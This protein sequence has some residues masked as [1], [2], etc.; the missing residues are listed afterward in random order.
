MASYD[1][2]GPINEATQFRRRTV[3]TLNGTPCYSPWTTPVTVAVNLISPGVIAADQGL[4]IGNS[5]P[6]PF[7]STTSAT[8]S[9]TI[10]Y[11]WQSNTVGCMAA[12]TD[13]PMATSSTYDAPAISQTTYYR[14]VATST[15]DGVPCSAA[16]NCLTVT[17]SDNVPPV[18][19]CPSAQS[20]QCTIGELPPYASYEDFT[21]AG[22]SASD[23][24]VLNTASFT[25]V[26][27]TSDM[28]SC[29]ETITR[30]Y[31]I[32][33]Q[34]GNSSTCAQVITVD[35]TTPPSLS[36]CIESL[37]GSAECDGLGNNI[38]AAAAWN[39]ANVA[40]L[41]GCATDNCSSVTITSNYSTNASNVPGC[42]GT[43]TLTVTYTATDG[44]GNATTT[45]GVFTI[46][47]TTPPVIGTQAMGQTVQCDG[48][49]N[50]AAL[51]SW[52]DSHGGA[53]AS[54]ACGTVIWSNN[55]TAL[56]DLCGATGTAT[57]E[58]YASDGCGNTSTTTATFTIEDTT[59]PIVTCPPSITISGCGTNDIPAPHPAYNETGAFLTLTELEAAGG[60]AT[61]NCDLVE[62]EIFYQDFPS[63]TCPLV[64]TRVWTA[65]DAC[66]LLDT[67]QQIIRIYDTTFPVFVDPN[68][69]TLTTSA[70]AECPA[71]GGVTGI[72]V[73]PV[74]SGA[75]FLVHG[76]SQSAPI[77]VSPA[78]ANPGEYSDNCQASLSLVSITPGGNACS[79]TYTLLWYV[80]DECGNIVPQNQV[81]TVVD[82]T[83][84]VWTTAPGAL[85]MTLECSDAAG[86][87]AAQALFPTAS[88]N[89]DN[90]VTNIV[91]VSGPFVPGMTCPQEGTYTNTWTVTDD[92]G[93]TSLVYTQVITI[94]D[95]TAPVITICPANI[96]IE[97][98]ASTDPA[99]NTA[100]GTATAT[101]N[102]DGMPDVQYSDMTVQSMSCP[103][104]YTI[105]RT[106][107]A[108][109][110]CGN[111][112]NCVQVITIDDS[113]APVITFCP[114]DVTIECSES[115]D[116]TVNMTLGIA[117]ATDNC[118]GMPVV[119]YED[120]S[121][122]G[123]C[124]QE[125][126]I[127]RTWTATDACGNSTNCV[128]VITVDDSTPPMITA[129]ADTVINCL[130]ASGYLPLYARGEGERILVNSPMEVEGLYNT[131][132]ANFGPL[133]GDTITADIILM[134]DGVV[135]VTDGCEPTSQDMTGKIALIDR[136]VCLFTYK[137][138]NAQNAGAIA[139]IIANNDMVNPD[140]PIGMGGTDPS[141]MI[142]TVSISYNDGV[143]LKAALAAGP[144]NASMFGIPVFEVSD[145]C[146]GEPLVT[147]TDE[148]IEGNCVGNYTILRTY[149]A[150]DDCGNIGSDVQVITVIDT[151][152]PVITCPVDVTIECT[153]S[154]DPAVNSTLGVATA[155]DGC[156]D[157]PVIAYSDATLEGDCP[158]EYT[159]TRTWSATDDCGNTTTCVQVITVDDST[160]PVITCPP[161]LTIQ[162]DAELDLSIENPVIAT[163]LGSATATDN[164]DGMPEITD[165]YD[166]MAFS[167][168]CGPTGSQTVTFTATDACGNSTA[169]TAIIQVVD[170]VPPVC[171]TADITIDTVIDPAT[172]I[173]MIDPSWI[174]NG[175]FDDCGDVTISV[176][177]ESIACEDEGPNVITLT[178]TDECGNTSQCTATLTLD[179]ID[180]CISVVSWVYL[181]GS[182]TAPNGEPVWTVP[183][184]TTLNDLLVL[185]G[186]FY[187]DPFFGPQYSPPG[188]PYDVA[189]WNYMGTEG[190]AYDSNMDPMNG[191][192]N[193]PP[194]VVDWVL[195]SLRDTVIGPPVCMAAALLHNDGTIEFV[196]PFDCCDQDVYDSYY[197]VVEHRNHLIV[198]SDI[199]IPVNLVNSTITY[200]FRIQDSYLDNPFMFEFIKGQ[201]E[202]L[203]GIW[204]MYAANGEQV[205][206]GAA[207]I[208]I[209]QDDRTRWSDDNGD[210]GLYRIGDYNMNA[211]VNFNDRVTWERNNGNSSSVPRD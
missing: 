84:P 187:D 78:A 16:S 124:P 44:C 210:Y 110:A 56:S 61:D 1:P 115:T 26:S 144:V 70:G 135:P 146:T 186:Q 167:D 122:P 60:T 134:D 199:P 10:T 154:I 118:D 137:V 203:P 120:A 67:C 173:I 82:N 58:F 132:E 69:V 77:M 103:Q 17:L 185:P 31:R 90:D 35:D 40:Y 45:T 127:T 79:K 193:Y 65:V 136:N 105:T 98:T 182:A 142:P 149:Y 170:N 68:D 155:T 6:V 53:T 143:A 125:Y 114:T 99:I 27:E 181:E 129:P 7:T 153:E 73:G 30:V 161:T 41:E 139:V 19:N 133:L 152:G 189:P 121:V 97:C 96:T 100:L 162:C 51:N 43:F 22:G 88:D 33:D 93:N 171:M 23:N 111:S 204:A 148:I 126:T 37:N 12:F 200:D 14:R 52:L 50:T 141:I 59:P 108:T 196:Q 150:E 47:D 168:E 166:P 138:L 106:W 94:V 28:M 192:A 87:S 180:P 46:V 81:F 197:V 156:S 157:M 38:L 15:L 205:I 198:M 151:I 29:P 202:I 117:T 119:V 83:A 207:D 188:Q 9:G 54:D 63:G 39:N 48:A 8:G 32:S 95:N 140:N 109:D 36:G 64:I 175:S 169:C 3:I 91:E 194:T 209:N 174:D 183:M 211:D 86:I 102:C 145:N 92:C 25:L 195:V 2:P 107:T 112:T 85:D 4:C 21:V 113:T 147:T 101:D 123:E 116:P 131:A 130:V 49:G 158:Q 178:V 128:Q 75:V 160:P 179:C 172:G 176:F 165:N 206:S 62:A 42:G 89:C 20:T 201:K 18:I 191:D 184:R 164:C 80:V 57:V 177:P 5:D 104:E 55:F 71:V 13:I 72:S 208:D 163:W 11:Q 159:I 24:C 190:D 74:Q 34:A 76:V 66:G